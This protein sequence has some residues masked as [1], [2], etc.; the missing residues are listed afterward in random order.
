MKYFSTIYVIEF[1]KLYFNYFSVESETL[2]FSIG[3]AKLRAEFFGM[4]NVE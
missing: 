2:F 3:L 4:L 1:L